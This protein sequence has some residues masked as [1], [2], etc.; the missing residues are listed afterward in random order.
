MFNRS[1]KEVLVV[2]AGPVGL[3]A[4]VVLARLGVK[5]HII[6]EA[7]GPASHSYALA[8]H[9]EALEL[10][11]ECG[12]ASK[13]I[14]K[15]RVL[16]TIGLY[17]A[18]EQRAQLDL[19]V[20]RSNFPFVAILSQASFEELL[21]EVLHEQ[22][23]KVEWSHRLARFE[24]GEGVVNVSIDTLEKD[25]AG[26]AYSE[27]GSLVS[28]SRNEKVHFVLGAD[29]YESLVRR[30]LG[31]KFDSLRAPQRFAVFECRATETL[32]D[33]VRVVLDEATTNVLWPMPEGRYRWSFEVTDLVSEVEPRHKDRLIVDTGSSDSPFLQLAFA[34]RLAAERAPWFRDPMKST[35]FRVLTRFEQRLAESFGRDRIW[36]AGDAAHMTGPVGVQSMNVGMREAA[37]LAKAFAHLLHGTAPPDVLTSYE[38]SRLAEWRYLLGQGAGVSAKSDADPWVAERA[39]RMV[40]CM[41]ASGT[42]LAQ[43]LGQLGLESR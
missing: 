16:R 41:P 23:V 4:G 37:E 38:Q 17:D 21:A 18:K 9:P 2:G 39:Q 27:I 33:E 10:L 1:E 22:G 29:G 11:D 15:A 30:Q 5:P 34:R 42:H 31:I 13:V 26:Y 40:S 14:S 32:P 8:L 28:H 6:D 36:L 25:S 3:F 20:L 12:L 43:L 7:D 35:F 19:S 24:P